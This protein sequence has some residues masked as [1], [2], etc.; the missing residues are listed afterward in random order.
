MTAYQG[1]MRTGPIAADADLEHLAE[2]VLVS[3]LPRKPL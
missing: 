3:V 2:E 1:H